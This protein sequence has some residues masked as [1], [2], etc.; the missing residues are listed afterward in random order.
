MGE[1]GI[2]KKPIRNHIKWRLERGMV[3]WFRRTSTFAIRLKSAHSTDKWVVNR[4][5]YIKLKKLQF[6]IDYNSGA[7]EAQSLERDLSKAEKSRI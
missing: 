1:K 5:V 3:G 4:V 2:K 6:Q 7:F